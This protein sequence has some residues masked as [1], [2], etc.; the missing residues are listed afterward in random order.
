MM[1]SY[2]N[3]MN[4]FSRQMKEMKGINMTEDKNVYE[5][6]IVEGNSVMEHQFIVAKNEEE[7]KIK[8]AVTHP[9]YFTLGGNTKSEMFVRPF[10]F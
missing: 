6:I 3:P 9:A 10:C 8:M 7:A 1:E 2:K 4:V 5:V